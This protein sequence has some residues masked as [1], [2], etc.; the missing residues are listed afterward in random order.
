MSD[1]LQGRKFS[2]STR[3]GE[4]C[5]CNRLDIDRHDSGDRLEVTENT[6]KRDKVREGTLRKMGMLAEICRT[7]GQI[8]TLFKKD[9]SSVTSRLSFP[10]PATRVEQETGVCWVSLTKRRH[11]PHERWPAKLPAGSREGD[12]TDERHGRGTRSLSTVLRLSDPLHLLALS[13]KERSM[14]HALLIWRVIPMVWLAL[15]LCV[16]YA[17]SQA[18]LNVQ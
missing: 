17:S 1:C 4:I 13:E 6:G 3:T 18:G 15:G 8:F 5:S 10:A 12:D 2:G 14:P 16:P 9:Q 11:F 7:E